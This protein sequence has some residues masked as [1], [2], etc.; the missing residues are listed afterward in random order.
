MKKPDKVSWRF[1]SKSAK[2]TF[3]AERSIFGAHIE[4][5]GENLATVD[6]YPKNEPNVPRLI[7]YDD[8]EHIMTI[9][10]DRENRRARV[11]IDPAL[12]VRRDSCDGS[13]IIELT[14]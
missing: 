8:E 7:V 3:S 5:N 12:V 9:T 13:I 10:V 6:F 4:A 2:G 1:N 14:E 11:V